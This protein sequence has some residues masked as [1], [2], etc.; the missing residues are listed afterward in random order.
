MEQLIKG[1]RRTYSGG[2]VVLS[3]PQGTVQ[4]QPG[5]APLRAAEDL[6]RPLA[7]RDATIEGPFGVVTYEGEYGVVVNA[8]TPAEQNTIAIV[9][10]DH[11]Y[12]S[13]HARATD[14]AAFATFLDV[15]RRVAHLF[16]LGQGTD[17]RRRYFYTP[18]P[19]WTGIARPFSTLWLAPDCGHHRATI[20]VFHARPQRNS[21]PTVMFRQMFEQLSRE[22]GV[23]PREEP[24]A[25]EATS[26]LRGQLVTVRGVVGDAPMVVSDAGLTDNRMLYLLRLETASAVHE[27]HLPVFRACVESV[28]ELPTP[29]SDVD[30][31]IEWFAGT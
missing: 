24:H 6:W 31:L 23:L 13:I 14:P 9:Y 20:Q 7:P 10:G 22:F 8:V 18:P 15:A 28:Q 16:P 29:R 11:T 27:R 3:N 17:R 21:G 19:G 25:I 5:L 12:T 2:G 4:I 30:V 26:G 1:W